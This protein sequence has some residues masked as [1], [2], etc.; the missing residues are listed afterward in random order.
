ML[1]AAAARVEELSAA[2]LSAEDDYIRLAAAAHA[3]GHLDWQGLIQAYERIRA[4]G[5]PGYSQ[6]WLNHIPHDLN[7]MRRYAASAPTNE[8][9]TWSGEGGWEALDR[10]RIP[11]NGTH[12]AFVLFGNAGAP[13]HISYTYKFRPLLKQLEH[14]GMAWDAWKAWPAAN[15][16]DAVALRRQLAQRYHWTNVA[17]SDSETVPE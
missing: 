4:G 16:K 12:V 13:I 1:D 15:R 2:Q 5:R 6:R 9:G 7:S 14:G 3:A 8:D 11:A 17:D 10:H